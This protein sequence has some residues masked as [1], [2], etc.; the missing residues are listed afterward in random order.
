MGSS[1]SVP[2]LRAMTTPVPG[3]ASALMGYWYVQGVVPT[4][5]EKNAY[6]SLEH[7]EWT[8]EAAGKLRVTFTYRSGDYDGTEPA[9]KMGRRAACCR[10]ARSSIRRRRRSG[11]SPAACGVPHAC[12]SALHHPASRS[13]LAHVRRVPGPPYLWIMS[14]QPKIQEDLYSSLTKRA[15]DEW[16]YAADK[17]LRVRQF[18]DEKDYPKSPTAG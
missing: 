7:Y 18:W 12:V 3:G 6:N 14:R 10:T 1:N 2:A 8:D 5:F 17:I 13:D 9:S 4:I 16:G 11:G 15:V